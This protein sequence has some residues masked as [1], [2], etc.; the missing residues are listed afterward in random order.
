M[1][2]VKE[3]G[4]ST[5]V[6]TTD[7]TGKEVRI[8]AVARDLLN[9]V[10]GGYL[11]CQ[12]IIP[13]FHSFDGAKAIVISGGAQG[14]Q[15]TFVTRTKDSANDLMASF[16]SAHDLSHQIPK[17]S[18]FSLTQLVEEARALKHNYLG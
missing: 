3:Q 9:A 12:K 15:E 14:G 11:P 1:P 8:A 5:E 17:L 18:R 4:T 7:L 16:K 6:F 2:R 13:L 10:W